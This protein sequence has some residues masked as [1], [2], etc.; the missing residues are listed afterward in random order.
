MKQ[1]MM[2]EDG[3]SLLEVLIATAVFTA[4]IAPMLYAVATGQRLAR[5]QP[6]A[7]DLQQRL[8]VVADRLQRDL[9]LAGAGPLHGSAIGN[10]NEHLPPILPARTGTRTP[11]AELS[12]FQDRISILYVPDGAAPVSL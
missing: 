12:A 2:K 4:A 9:S 10:L 6:E 11:D 8:R 1:Q 3:F 5:A 7:S